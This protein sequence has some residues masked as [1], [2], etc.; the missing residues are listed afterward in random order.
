MIATE[1]NILKKVKHD[2]IITLFEM[3]EIDNRI[4]LVMGL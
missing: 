1:V 3:Y 2:N 4:Y